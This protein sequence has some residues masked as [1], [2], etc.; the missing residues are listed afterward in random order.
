[1]KRIAVIVGFALVVGGCTEVEFGTPSTDPLRDQSM[2]D[3][4]ALISQKCTLCHD[5]TRIDMTRKTR[6]EWTQRISRCQG[7]GAQINEVEKKDISDYL[8][9]RR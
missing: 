9:L 6:D 8:Y 2:T 4:A 3:P 5:R 1:M 7:Y